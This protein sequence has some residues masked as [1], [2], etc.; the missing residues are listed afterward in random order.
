MKDAVA[1]LFVKVANSTRLLIT[2]AVTVWLTC[3]L[4]Y[5]AIEDKPLIEALWWG[6]VT[7]S[8][9]GYGDSFPV[10]TPGRFIG[11][12]LIVS[13]VILTAMAISQLSAELIVD[14]D[15]FTHEEQEELARLERENNALLRAVLARLA[16][17]QA[18]ADALA[19]VSTAAD[20]ADTAT[21]H[22][23]GP[24]ATAQTLA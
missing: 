22:P 19:T 8:T 3:S 15:A 20:A 13:M 2:T 12:C 7:G 23:A 21:K 24:A 10:S 16:G 9:V 18:V 14:R 6:I 1:T 4:A 11:A 5:C 17:D